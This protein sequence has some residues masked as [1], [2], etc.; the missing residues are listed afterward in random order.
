MKILM[1]TLQ[2]KKSSINSLNDLI[3]D[4]IS[5]QKLNPIVTE[6]LHFTLQLLQVKN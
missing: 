4:M 1:I 3:A 6:L 2:E 5:N